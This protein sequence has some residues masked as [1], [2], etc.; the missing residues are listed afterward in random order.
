MTIDVSSKQILSIVRNYDEDT[1]EL[2][3]ARDT[4]VKY[5]FVPGFGFYD[6]GLLNILGN[7]TA[8][9]TAVWRELLDLGMFANFPGFLISDVGTRQDT[10]IL[11]VP[12]G[13]GAK[14]KTNGLPI[15]QAVMPLP[16]NMQAAPS[17]MALVE[18]MVQTGQRVGGTAEMPTGE[19]RADAPVG[20]T[21]ALIEGATKITN[22]VHKRMHASQATE[23][24]LLANVFREHPESFWQKNRKPARKW[25]EETFLQALNDCNL[26]PQADPNTA[27]QIQRLMK[28][29]A[30][31]ALQ[32][33][34]PSLYDPI[35]IDKMCIRALGFSNPEEFMAPISAMGEK[36]PE[37]T[38]MEQEGAA[39]EQ[40]AKSK[41]ILAQAKS[42][43][44]KA[45]ID[46]EKSRLEMDMGK[47]EGG[48]QP[49]DVV[50]VKTALMDA[51]T[52]AKQV[53][54][55][56]ADLALRSKNEVAERQSAEHLAT[57]NL[58]K[59]ILI[60]NSTQAHENAHKA[61][62]V[63]QQQNESAMSAQTEAQRMAFEG[64]H[65]VADR[66]TKSGLESEKLKAMSKAKTT[67]PKNGNKK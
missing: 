22:S 31:K 40:D 11:R 12:P 4:F 54:V 34:S 21:L 10:N 20:T 16:Y 46:I 44:V 30:V 17:M 3:E 36:P 29:A 61:V 28:L 15:N 24:Q 57:M 43:E 45:K 13:G 42:D 55:D 32:A 25:D 64:E 59:E 53:D 18:N 52:K 67:Q 1:K 47:G 5:T 48:M 50:K 65:K 58:A 60:H 35:A 56:Q 66:E 63:A 51:H 41:A 23:L 62:D 14:V 19:G 49:L 38:K 9:V 26:V 33:A 39:K 37:L 7:T 6:I 8:A 27:S 2:P